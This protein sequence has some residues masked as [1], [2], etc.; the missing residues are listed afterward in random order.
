MKKIEHRPFIETAVSAY[1]NS[2]SRSEKPLFPVI[3]DRDAW[4][5]LD[6]EVKAGLIRTGEETERSGLPRGLSPGGRRGNGGRRR[7]GRRRTG[8]A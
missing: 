4:D 7:S 5:S 6:N 3:S 1:L 2:G 8:S